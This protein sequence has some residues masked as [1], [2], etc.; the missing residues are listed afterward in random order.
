MAHWENFNDSYSVAKL[1]TYFSCPLVYLKLEN[2]N[3]ILSLLCFVLIIPE[4][5]KS[6]CILACYCNVKQYTTDCNVSGFN[7]K[8][9]ILNILSAGFFGSKFHF[10]KTVLFP[11]WVTPEKIR[12]CHN[13]PK[14]IKC[15]ILTR[16]TKSLTRTKLYP[17]GSWIYM[18]ATPW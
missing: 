3:F 11:L 9:D 8:L 7:F 13:L 4:F 1:L 6:C 5:S 14:E 10:A 17:C 2:Y 15:R 12:K 18:Q 16:S